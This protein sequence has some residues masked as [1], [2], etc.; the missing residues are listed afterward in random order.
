MCKAHFAILYQLHLDQGFP[1]IALIEAE[2]AGD[3]RVAI[4]D[5]DRRNAEI[6]YRQ[7][8]SEDCRSFIESTYASVMK[9]M[10]ES[11]YSEA[12]DPLLALAFLQ[13]IVATALWKYGLDAGKE[14]TKFA[15]EFDRLDVETE[16]MR[17]Y[18]LATSEHSARH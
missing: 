9:K 11:S 3:M 16:R 1:R 10:S 13:E 8:F 17:L 14:L 5:D 7:L 12:A 15:R 6:Y 18:E 2:V 4:T